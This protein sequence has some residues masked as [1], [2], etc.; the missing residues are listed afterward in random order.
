MK[1]YA[2][3][4]NLDNLKKSASGGAFSRITNAIIEGV[5]DGNYAIYGVGWNDKLEVCHMRIDNIEEIERL[6]GSKYVNSNMG[7]IFLLVQKDLEEGRRVVFSGTPCQV[8][9]L[10]L[11]LNKNNISI[12]ELYTIDLICHGTPK[13]IVLSDYIDWC[14]K[15]YGSKVIAMRFRDKSVG[16]KR[17]P[18]SITMR[19]G[20][21]YKNTY[22]TQMYMRMFFSVLILNKRCF[23]CKYSNLDRKSDFTIGDFWGIEEIM[24]EFGK[25]LGVSLILANTKKSEKQIQKI[26]EG[27]VGDEIKEYVGDISI[28]L[29]KQ[30]NLHS[31]TEMPCRYQE[32]WNDYNKYGFEYC[33][34][35][36]NFLS[37][38]GRVKFYIKK[39]LYHFK[40]FDKKMG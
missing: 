18:I 28:I 25:K 1:I 10:Y 7:N 21:I 36:Y 17:Y 16:W 15:Y 26:F 12:E 5:T 39:I 8:H 34:S 20:K 27:N 22:E 37:L 23:S 40:Y 6:K 32:F 19:S 33:I 2:Y 30:H 29:D 9:A 13:S 38:N 14:N 35:K 11:F 31:S 24:P 3:C 4:G